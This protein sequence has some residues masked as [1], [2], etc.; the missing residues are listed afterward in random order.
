MGGASTGELWRD[1]K[2]TI[3]L[4]FAE[5][6]LWWAVKVVPQNMEE[7]L[8]MIRCVREYYERVLAMKNLR[9]LMEGNEQGERKPYRGE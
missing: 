5:T 6:F 4:Y 2:S 9:R 3:R 8:L 7:G 1:L